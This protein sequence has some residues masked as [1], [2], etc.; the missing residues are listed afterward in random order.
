MVTSSI[1]SGR[2]AKGAFFTPEMGQDLVAH[3]DL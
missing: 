1:H 3:P 2:K